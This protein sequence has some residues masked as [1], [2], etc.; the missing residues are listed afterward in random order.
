MLL[1]FQERMVL[2]Q[3]ARGG[4]NNNQRGRGGR[5]NRQIQVRGGAVAKGGG[6]GSS[7]ARSPQSRGRTLK[8]MHHKAS[9][10]N[11]VGAGSLRV[12]LMSNLPRDRQIHIRL[13]FDGI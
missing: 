13:C 12:Y 11:I 10:K 8:L 2:L 7:S 9:S 3:G 6:R 5:N 4:G 1:N